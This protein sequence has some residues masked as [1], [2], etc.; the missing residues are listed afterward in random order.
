MHL[1]TSLCYLLILFFSFNCSIQGQNTTDEISTLTSVSV[2]TTTTTISETTTSNVSLSCPGGHIDPPKCEKCSQNYTTK[3]GTCIEIKNEVKPSLVNGRRIFLIFLACLLTVVLLI[4]MLFVYKRVNQQYQR[5]LPSNP[6]NS[7]NTS[8]ISNRFSTMLRSFR[9]NKRGRY[10]FFSISNNNSSLG[11]YRQ[12]DTSRAHLNENPDEALL[13]DDPYT[14]GFNNSSAN[15]YR[16][17]TL[18]VT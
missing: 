8:N 18:S 1:T 10:N 12:P 5:R 11:Q 13:F 7:S 9:L 17:L 16:T 2:N 14:D 3:N 15:P 6:G 4:S